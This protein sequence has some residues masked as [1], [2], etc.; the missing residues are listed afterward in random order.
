MTKKRN[1]K[2]ALPAEE[3]RLLRV[4]ELTKIDE[5]KR[6]GSLLCETREP[7][8][9]KWRPVLQHEASEAG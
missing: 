8:R 6:P 3:A 2:K 9:R 1:M 5:R 7:A 4:K